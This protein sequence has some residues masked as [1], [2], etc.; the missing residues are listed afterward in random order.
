M[1]LEIDDLSK[2]GLMAGNGDTVYKEMSV[3][4]LGHFTAYHNR[5]IKAV[6][7]DRT[8]VRMM[9]DCRIIRVLTRR[10]DEL[11]FNL[12]HPNPAQDDYQDYIKVSREFFEWAF[13]TAEEKQEKEQRAQMEKSAIDNEIERIQR[14]VMLIGSDN[15]P[16]TFRPDTHNQ[17]LENVALN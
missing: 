10:G 8:I 7:Q 4:D 13:L 14:T 1:D 12:D 9:K 16:Q 17:N 6:F 2:A 15:A 11:L 3:K 5:A